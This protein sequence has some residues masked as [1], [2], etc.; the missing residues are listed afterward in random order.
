M[1]NKFARFAWIRVDYPIRGDSYTND[2]SK[3]ILNMLQNS[4]MSRLSGEERER[5]KS[6][7]LYPVCLISYH[8][9]LFLRCTIESNIKC[10]KW[11]NNRLVTVAFHSVEELQKLMF[12]III[13]R[14]KKITRWNL[15]LRQLPL[16]QL[17]AFIKSIEIED[18]EGVIAS[19]KKTAVV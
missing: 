13:S 7:V 17:E 2:L 1:F 9:D 19:L 12:V 15:D 6:W 18:R 10:S 4:A 14:F 16:P 5:M 11:S 3:F 8:V